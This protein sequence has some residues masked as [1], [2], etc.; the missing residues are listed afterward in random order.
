M[1]SEII[2]VVLGA[3]GYGQLVS[4]TLGACS[5]A[6]EESFV[7]VKSAPYCL[8]PRQIRRLAR[9]GGIGRRL[10]EMAKHARFPL[11]VPVPPS[12]RA[13]SASPPVLSLSAI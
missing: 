8:Q 9:L 11:L 12:W 6:L 1:P 7:I 2:A 3:E 5:R 4:R 13:G 10:I